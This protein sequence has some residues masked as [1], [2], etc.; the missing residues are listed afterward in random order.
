MNARSLVL[1]LVTL[2][3][4]CDKGIDPSAIDPHRDAVQRTLAALDDIASK[5]PSITLVDPST[6][7]AITATRF[8]TDDQLAGRVSLSSTI[9]GA[10]PDGILVDASLIGPG[11]TQNFDVPIADRG[12]FLA[13]A[14]R[15]VASRASLPGV[16]ASAVE[17]CRRV[18]ALKS[19]VVIRQVQRT[20]P[21]VSSPTSFETGA[22]VGEALAFELEG[23]TARFVGGF[24]FEAGNSADVRV[25]WEQN[26]E[27]QRE[28]WLASDLTYNAYVALSEGMRARA[29][30]VRLPPT[31][32]YRST[33]L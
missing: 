19:V 22:Y 20:A 13:G 17:D 7:I 24:R 1:T 3:T 6:T 23:R 11:H 21:Q 2:L 8:G 28:Q 16:T 31:E 33:L 14:R 27:Y 25:R 5:L 9:T 18:A 29:P 26:R 12:A 30:G 4:A 32:F 15:V 10:F